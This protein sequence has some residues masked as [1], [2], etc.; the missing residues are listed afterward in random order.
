MIIRKAEEKDLAQIVNLYDKFL[1]YMCKFGKFVKDKNFHIDSKIEI[2]NA[3]TRRI[4]S[5]AKKIFLVAEEKDKILGFIEA[6]IM[7]QRDSKTKRK[8]IEIVDIYVKNKRKGVGNKLFKEIE[9][10]SKLEEANFIQWEFL[11]GN[12]SAENFCIKNK[13]KYFRVKMLKRLK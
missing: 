4:K 7:S 11:H 3:L 13:F 1:K 10:W 9:K 5:S 12:K 8:V 2:K 6:E